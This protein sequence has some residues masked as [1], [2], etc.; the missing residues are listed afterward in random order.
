MAKS[1]SERIL[2]TPSS[3]TKSHYLYV[4]ET[5][6]LK[7]LQPHV[8]HREKLESFLFFI[9]T[10]GCG[11]LTY[12]NTTYSIKAG[13]CVWLNC[14]EGYS[15]ESSVSEPWTLKWVHFFGTQ[16]NDFY[17]HYKDLDGPSI[18]TP[19]SL[20]PYVELLQAVYQTRL[21]KDGLSDLTSH[22]LLTNL[23]TQI[24]CDT[25]TGLTGA[26]TP[27]KYRNIRNYI[28]DH[29]QERISLD[30]LSELFFISKY[31]LVREYQRLFG[32]TILT[33]LTMKRLSHAKSMLRFSDESIETIA[34]SCG[35]QTSSYFI[36]VFKRFE[37]ITPLEYRRK[38]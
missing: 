12:R 23:I 5:G 27:E 20:S 21:R 25:L 37:N 35:F 19:A 22:N 24:F 18:F 29:Y 28:E 9:I 32:T 36:K 26:G 8:S 6:T 31:H 1:V 38:W 2:V 15:H 11:T 16:A 10:E 7:S 4:Q 13:D 33:D 30:Q 3:Y 14:L 34:V 17:S